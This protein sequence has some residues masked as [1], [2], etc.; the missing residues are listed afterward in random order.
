M[1]TL[2]PALAAAAALALAGCAELSQLAESAIQK[3]KLTFRSAEIQSVDLE[4]ATVGF[5]FD[6]DNPNGFGLD[7]ARI[8]YGVEVQGQ[9]VATGD[10]PGGLKI[11]ASGKAPVT[12]P[13]K[14]RFADVPGIL[15]LFRARDA[16]QYKLSGDLGLRSPVGTIDVPV[17]HSASLPLPRLPSFSLDGLS[18]RSVSLDRLK[19]DVKVKVQNPNRFPIPAGRMDYALSLAGAEVARGQGKPVGSVPGGQS[20][21]VSIPVDVSVS[22]AQR[23][24]TAL[25]RGAGVDVGVKGQAELAGLPIPLDLGDKLSGR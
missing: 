20:V 4:A 24:A 23:A 10:L 18:L 16:L 2:R 5:T 21:T 19:L 14:I 8:G 9:R 25:M 3:P 15:G 1:R 7:L 12:F 13:V 17:S 6:L 11:P 22:E